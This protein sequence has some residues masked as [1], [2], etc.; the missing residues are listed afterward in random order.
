MIFDV[1]IAI[2]YGPIVCDNFAVMLYPYLP[3]LFFVYLFAGLFSHLPFC[4][5]TFSPSI[6]IVCGIS[7]LLPVRLKCHNGHYKMIEYICRFPFELYHF[8]EYTH[9]WF[10]FLFCWLLLLLYILLNIL[11]Y[12]R[13]YCIPYSLINTV[14]IEFWYQLLPVR[15]I[16]HISRTWWHV[17]WKLPIH[18]SLTC[19][20]Y[21]YMKLK[22][23]EWSFQ[24]YSFRFQIQ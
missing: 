15:T 22:E 16:W 2:L 13:L 5:F 10:C 24:Q 3:L 12:D 17:P 4:S 14:L 6:F 7:C 9:A 19:P 18:C 23:V 21:T 11:P 1:G 20:G 8:F